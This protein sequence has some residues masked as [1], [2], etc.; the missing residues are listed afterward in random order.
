[1]QT[2]CQSY[3]KTS[4]KICLLITTV[5]SLVCHLLF[6]LLNAIAEGV[7]SSYACP[8]PSPGMD[9]SERKY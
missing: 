9:F 8:L 6:I 5:V 3:T 4:Q 2:C 1:M 7:L